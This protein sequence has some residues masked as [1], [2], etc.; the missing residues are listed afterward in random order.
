[1]IAPSVSRTANQL[2]NPSTPDLPWEHPPRGH[3]EVVAPAARAAY[4]RRLVAA[5]RDT[6]IPVVRQYVHALIGQLDA[7]A[8]RGITS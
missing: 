1:M 7:L 5:Y 3:V 4:R 6:P 2:A 8:A